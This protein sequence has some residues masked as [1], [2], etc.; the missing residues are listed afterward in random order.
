V[1]FTTVS[2]KY[3]AQSVHAIPRIPFGKY[4]LRTTLVFRTLSYFYCIDTALRGGFGGN[5]ID[6]VTNGSSYLATICELSHGSPVTS[7]EEFPVSLRPSIT[8]RRSKYTVLGRS[9]GQS[10]T[11]TLG[12]AG[13]AIVPLSHPEMSR[14]PKCDSQPFCQLRNTIRF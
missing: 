7:S 13:T 3:E 6:N 2:A 11:V 9:V 10:R 12:L 14:W 8:M 4:F 1:T 5:R